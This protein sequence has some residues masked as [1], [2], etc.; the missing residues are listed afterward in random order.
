MTPNMQKGWE[1]QGGHPCDGDTYHWAGNC[2]KD[3]LWVVRVEVW[4]REA[5]LWNIPT[6]GYV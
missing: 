3:W 5:P 4:E 2:A 6:E 1:V